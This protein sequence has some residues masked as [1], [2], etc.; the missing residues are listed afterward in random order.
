MADFNCCLERAFQVAYGRD[1]MSAETKETILFRQLQEGLRME[2]L[3]GPA[4]S[5]ALGY[6]ILCAAAKTEKRLLAELRK[7]QLKPTVPPR[8]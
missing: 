1:R 4:V 3:R 7:H 6:K 5:G 2:L 8:Q